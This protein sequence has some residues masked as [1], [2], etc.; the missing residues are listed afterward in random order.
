MLTREQFN[1]ILLPQMGGGVPTAWEPDAQPNSNIVRAVIVQG[2]SQQRIVIKQLDAAHIDGRFNLTGA[3]FWATRFE[4]QLAALRACVESSDSKLAT[5]VPRPLAWDASTLSLCMNE[6]AGEKL[7]ALLGRA[8]RWLPDKKSWQAAMQA[9]RDA[10]EW[11]GA[12]HRLDTAVL[13]MPRPADR[14][15][16]WERYC[17]S[18]MHHITSCGCL[19][20]AL[21]HQLQAQQMAL[22]DSW[23]EFGAEVLLHNDFQSHNI[24]W[25]GSGIVVLDF[26]GVSTGHREWDIIKIFHSI[27]KWALGRPFCGRRVQALHKA[28][29]EGYGSP[30]QVGGATWRTYEFAWALDKLSDFAEDNALARPTTAVHLRTRFLLKLLLAQGG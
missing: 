17:V 13:G 5:R 23:T 15:E 29:L 16:D 30:V 4:A 1:A 2:V 12:F 14:R 25:T 18:R 11:L 24:L 26:T 7:D 9:C 20:A 3:S 10:G 27:S 6:V 28:F 21:C 19:P 22:L 8:I